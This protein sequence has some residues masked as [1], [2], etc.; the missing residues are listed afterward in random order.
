[1]NRDGI[2]ASAADAIGDTP[3]VALDRLTAGLEGRILAKLDML[4]PGFPRRTEPPG[5]SSTMRKR[6]VSCCPGSPWSN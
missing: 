5:K 1:M 2:C 6:P 4:N 3:L